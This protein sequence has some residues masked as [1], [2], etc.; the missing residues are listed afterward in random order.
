[1]KFALKETRLGLRDSHTRIAFRYGNT[2]LTECPQA[3]FEVV[4]ETDTGVA[5]GYSGD[6]LPPGWFDKTPGRS[7]PDQIGDMLAAV[8]TATDAF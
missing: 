7:F 6:C 8:Q 4:I 5:S 1:M 2:C 3:I